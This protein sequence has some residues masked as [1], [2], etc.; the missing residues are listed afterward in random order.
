MLTRIL[1]DVGHD[2]GRHKKLLGL[3]SA[4]IMLSMLFAACGNSPDSP[5]LIPASQEPTA[6]GIPTNIPAVDLTKT[7]P[8]V[9]LTSTPTE[10]PANE[11]DLSKRV[12]IKQLY[13][14]WEKALNFVDSPDVLEPGAIPFCFVGDKMFVCMQGSDI[15]PHTLVA[16]YGQENVQ[17]VTMKRNDVSASIAGSFYHT[18]YMNDSEINTLVTPVFPTQAPAGYN[19]LQQGP[20]IDINPIKEANSI[21]NLA[22]YARQ[23][24]FNIYNGNSHKMYLIRSEGLTDAQ[25]N[26]IKSLY[27]QGGVGVVQIYPTSTMAQDAYDQFNK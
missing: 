22:K 25:I 11:P 14:K 18:L 15:D 5:T 27:A 2:Q 7:V 16:K 4:I 1:S 9:D 3:T 20:L 12:D 19:W 13:S 21:D 24:I 10:R 26:E 17:I 8:V 23:S 6:I